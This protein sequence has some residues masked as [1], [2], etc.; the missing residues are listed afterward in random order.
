LFLLQLRKKANLCSE[1]ME[2]MVNVTYL[3]I[4]LFYLPNSTSVLIE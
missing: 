1:G 3:Y 2:M 4:A